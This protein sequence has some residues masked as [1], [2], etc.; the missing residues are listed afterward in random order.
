MHLSFQISVQQISEINLIILKY[1]LTKCFTDILSFR[2]WLLVLTIN[3]IF[4]IGAGSGICNLIIPGF[5]CNFMR[6]STLL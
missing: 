1:V 2:K 3:L 5:W 6:Q 4:N